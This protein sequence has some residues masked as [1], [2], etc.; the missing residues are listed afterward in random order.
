M[1]I[2]VGQQM[3]NLNITKER[4]LFELFTGSNIQI[5]WFLHTIGKFF[6]FIFPIRSINRVISS[7]INR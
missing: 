1:Y 7:V 4:K 5:N 2:D 6:Q 3:F